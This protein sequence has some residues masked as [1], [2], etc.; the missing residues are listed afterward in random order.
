MFLPPIQTILAE[1][2]WEFS[3]T[4]GQS[5]MLLIDIYIYLFIYS[6]YFYLYMVH[7]ACST[8][9]QV[10]TPKISRGP[11]PPCTSCGPCAMARWMPLPLFWAA[12]GG[13]LDATRSPPRIKSTQFG[14]FLLKLPLFYGCL[15][16]PTHQ[17]KIVRK[18]GLFSFWGLGVQQGHLH[19]LHLLTSSPYSVLSQDIAWPHFLKKEEFHLNQCIPH[20]CTLPKNFPSTLKRLSEYIYSP[21]LRSCLSAASCQRLCWC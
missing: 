6:I 9:F 21:Q 5:E 16:P 14:K 19:L 4:L 1:T 3:P 18:H 15:T 10:P 13:M 2:T 11:F 8:H 7:A 20:V 12:W 17:K